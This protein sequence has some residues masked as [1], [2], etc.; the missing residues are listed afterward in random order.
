MRYWLTLFIV[1]GICL[2]LIKFFFNIIF[3]RLFFEL[4]LNYFLNQ[5]KRKLNLTKVCSSYILKAFGHF[6][7]NLGKK[8]EKYF[9]SRLKCR[10]SSS[11]LA[12]WKT[13]HITTNIPLLLLLLHCYYPTGTLL[14]HYI[15]GSTIVTLKCLLFLTITYF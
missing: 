9:L 1:R 4:F 12:L 11:S 15:G 7:C 13:S 8:K 3:L 2:C 10:F 14:L 6:H 5:F